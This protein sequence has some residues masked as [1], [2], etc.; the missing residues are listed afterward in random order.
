[1]DRISE[2]I[3]GSLH[4]TVKIW[5]SRSDVRNCRQ[6]H[7]WGCRPMAVCNCVYGVGRFV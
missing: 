4:E 1:L 7:D 3:I 5:S 2:R 6:S